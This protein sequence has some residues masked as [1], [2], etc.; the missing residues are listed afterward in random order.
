MN[1]ST[2][3]VLGE[4]VE[5]QDAVVPECWRMYPEVVGMERNVRCRASPA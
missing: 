4:L 2:A 3:P 5:E 1:A